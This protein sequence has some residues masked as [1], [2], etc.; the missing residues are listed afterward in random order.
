[1]VATLAIGTLYVHCAND[2][3]A[4][5]IWSALHYRKRSVVMV[6]MVELESVGS[7]SIRRLCDWNDASV[8]FN[9]IF[10]VTSLPG[11]Y[12][13]VMFPVFFTHA[14]S[15]SVWLWLQHACMR[16]LCWLV[17]SGKFLPTIT[18]RELCAVWAIQNIIPAKMK[19]MSTFIR[20]FITINSI[21]TVSDA[22]ALTD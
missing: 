20:S 16:S 9:W 6:E 1:M 8:C 12:I 7:L 14:T 21:F 11:Q 17:I 2:N 19:Y 5:E 22:I 10:P 3:G 4:H 13:T 18:I 15:L